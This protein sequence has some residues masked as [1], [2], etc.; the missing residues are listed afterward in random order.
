MKLWQ[1]I[2]ALLC[3]GCIYFTLI[4]LFF[5][6]IILFSD[7]GSANISAKSFLLIFPGGLLLAIGEQLLKNQKLSRALRFPLHYLITV[8]AIFLFLILPSNALVSA[9]TRFLVLVFLSALYWLCF[10]LIA[11]IKGCIRR[12]MEED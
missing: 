3:K 4:S 12:L 10:G 1:N 6:F 11:L 9:S 7:D 8:L 2:K 5:L